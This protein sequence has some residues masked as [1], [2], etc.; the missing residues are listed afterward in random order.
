MSVLLLQHRWGKIS[1][2]G[3]VSDDQN[4]AGH[5]LNRSLWATHCVAVRSAEGRGRAAELF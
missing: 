1:A 4:E 2:S 3:S 5:A